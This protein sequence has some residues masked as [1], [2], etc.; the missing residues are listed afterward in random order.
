[1][2][3]REFYRTGKEKVH[4]HSFSSESYRV[5]KGLTVFIVGDLRV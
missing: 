3:G 5:T 1:M 2:K 4:L